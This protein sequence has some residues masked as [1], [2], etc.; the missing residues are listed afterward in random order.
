MDALVRLHEL[1]WMA[2]APIYL[3]F[4]L[5]QWSL[6]GRFRASGAAHEL[7]LTL[8]RPWQV[9]GGWYCALLI[10]WQVG[11]GIFLLLLPLFPD[12]CL[13]VSRTAHGLFT[14]A[15]VA[16]FDASARLNLLLT[17]QGARGA[18]LPVEQAIVAFAATLGLFG[19]AGALERVP[20]DWVLTPIALAVAIVGVYILN[21]ATWRPFVVLAGQR[22]VRSIML[23]L[24]GDSASVDR[25]SLP[26]FFD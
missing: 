1:A 8:M 20:D 12:C 3:A 7:Q 19:V 11:V 2:G 14:V 6:L 26:R 18:R 15:A 23:E 16:I 4:G 9:I 25:P 13:P 21:V 17:L 24:E 22:Y 5:L 10:R